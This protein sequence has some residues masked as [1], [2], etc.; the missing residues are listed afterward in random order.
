[1][2]KYLYVIGRLGENKPK[3]VGNA[4]LVVYGDVPKNVELN[5]KKFLLYLYEK[6]FAY[7]HIVSHK[8]IVVE[9]R[10]SRERKRLMPVLYYYRLVPYTFKA[11]LN[12]TVMP[13]ASNLWRLEEEGEGVWKAVKIG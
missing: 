13:S 12:D 8:A 1:M 10:N 5:I 2:A 4:Y 11:I 6:S 7:Y 3:I 9:I